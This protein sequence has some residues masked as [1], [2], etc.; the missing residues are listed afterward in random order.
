MLCLLQGPLQHFTHFWVWQVVA[1]FP[2]QEHNGWVCSITGGETSSLK[3]RRG[4]LLTLG[5][6][7]FPKSV[8]STVVLLC[9]TRCLLRRG[10]STNGEGEESK[11]RFGRLRFVWVVC[12]LPTS[13]GLVAVGL[14]LVGVTRLPAVGVEFVLS[15]YRDIVCGICAEGLV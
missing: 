6:S 3:V 7:D 15:L 2:P 14:D 5:M 4:N 11:G 13:S 12:F 10:F 8:I 1:I 9:L